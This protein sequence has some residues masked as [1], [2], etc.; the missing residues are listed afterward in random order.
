MA[1][2]RR[3][4]TPQDDAFVGDTKNKKCRNEPKTC[5]KPVRTIGWTRLAVAYPAVFQ[6]G[7]QPPINGLSNIDTGSTLEVGNLRAPVAAYRQ[8]RTTDTE[9]KPL[10]MKV[11]APHSASSA[12]SPRIGK[13]IRGFADR[14]W[15]MIRSLRIV[16]R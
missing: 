8:S 2:T 15:S 7:A 6:S 12:R 10:R 13:L 4:A 3:N 11:T 5:L 1:L 14:R 9:K 16:T